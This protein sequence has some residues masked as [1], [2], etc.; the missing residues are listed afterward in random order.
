ME[1]AL[2]GDRALPFPHGGTQLFHRVALDRVGRAVAAALTR[3]PD[4]TWACNVADPYDWSYGG[5]AQ[6]VAEQL[7][8]TWEPDADQDHPWN[9]R[10]PVLADTTRLQTVLRV[11]APDPLSATTAQI[12][13]L[14]EHADRVAQVPPRG[15]G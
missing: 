5:L 7:G 1:K 11:T 2:R 4:G 14:A 10:H 9:A 12:A 6:L 13:W 15:A 8:H 3:A